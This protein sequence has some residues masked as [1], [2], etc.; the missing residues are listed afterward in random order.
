M[1]NTPDG[2]MLA[3]HDQAGEGN[4][5]TTYERISGMVGITHEICMVR[6]I[7]VDNPRDVLDGFFDMIKETKVYKELERDRDDIKARAQKE[8]DEMAKY[9]EFYYM[10][11]E[12]HSGRRD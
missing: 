2:M 8:I 3:L 11:K 1:K 12:A 7:G 6:P 4:Q 5:V 10:Y 9:K